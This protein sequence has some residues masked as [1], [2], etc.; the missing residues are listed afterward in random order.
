MNR[1]HHM[2]SDDRVDKRFLEQFR[3]QMLWMV[4]AV[5]VLA[6]IGLAVLSPWTSDDDSSSPAL[7]TPVSAGTPNP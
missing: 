1:Q 6:V 5:I 4:A 3:V 2:N 7:P